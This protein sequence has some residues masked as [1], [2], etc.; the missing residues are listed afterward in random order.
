MD[1]ASIMETS[2]GLSIMAS[3]GM[4]LAE[5]EAWVQPTAFVTS[6]FC[7]QWYVKTVMFVCNSFFT[8]TNFPFYLTNFNKFPWDIVAG[9]HHPAPMWNLCV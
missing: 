7:L 1:V 5:T 3:S 6:P 2:N 9:P 4:R 8:E